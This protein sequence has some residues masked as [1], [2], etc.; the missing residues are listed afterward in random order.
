LA[1]VTLLLLAVLQTVVDPFFITL[2]NVTYTSLPVLA[3][4]IFDQVETVG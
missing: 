2:Y 4:A 3:M 1:D